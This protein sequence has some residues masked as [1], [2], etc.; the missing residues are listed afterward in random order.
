MQA[1]SSSSAV[2]IYVGAIATA[3]AVIAFGLSTVLKASAAWSHPGVSDKTLLQSQIESSREI[4]RA[5]ATPVS[6]PPLPPITARPARDVA[7]AEARRNAAPPALSPQ[8][9]NA[10]AM[11]RPVA[12]PSA[13][14]GPSYPVRDR[15]T[16]GGW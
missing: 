10:M 8:A 14:A 15:M 11:E 9:R 5:L 7:A 16:G 12:A 1:R 2:L 6:I 13:Q 3:L 4:R